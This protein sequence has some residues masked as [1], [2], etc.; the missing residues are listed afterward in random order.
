[1]DSIADQ[2][3]RSLSRSTRVT[4]SER[5][6]GVYILP[7]PSAEENNERWFALGDQT[8]W[9]RQVLR[10]A[11]ECSMLLFDGNIP[12][13]VQRTLLVRCIGLE[14]IISRD[15][16]QRLRVSMEEKRAHVQ[17]VL[18]EQHRQRLRGVSS[19]ERLAL[20]SMRSSKSSRS[21]ARKVAM[22]IA[23]IP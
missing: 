16:F 23:S 12:T 14:H 19:S 10:D 3:S 22:A 9:A 17:S 20:V 8:N 15:V 2:P 18:Q 21:R 7:Y 5:S 6:E 1:M 13:H 4:F 11:V